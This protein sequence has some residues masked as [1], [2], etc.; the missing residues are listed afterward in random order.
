MAS[1]FL[2]L[3]PGGTPCSTPTRGRRRLSRGRSWALATALAHLL[4]SSPG[5]ANPLDADQSSTTRTEAPP[6]DDAAPLEENDDAPSPEDEPTADDE[7]VPDPTSA[8][9]RPADEDTADD[10]LADE[11]TADD[12]PDDDAPSHE[13]EPTAAPPIPPPT[14]RL[15]ADPAPPEVR[16]VYMGTP[17]YTRTGLHVRATLGA[18][19]LHIF[20]SSA[21]NTGDQPD[22]SVENSSVSAVPTT[23]ELWIGGAL[24]RDLALNLVIRGGRASNGRLHAD[25]RNAD[26]QD[27]GIQDADGQEVSLEGGLTTAFLGV[28]L[29]YHLDPAQGWLI[30]VAA[31]FER[32]QASFNRDTDPQVGGS[33]IAVSLLGGHDWWIG[34]DTAFGV[35][36][37]LDL[38]AATG[39][40]QAEVGQLQLENSDVD[41]Y[42]QAGVAL[43]LSYF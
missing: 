3:H 2:V 29:L 34:E 21:A 20:N 28:G 4:A 39:D 26:G 11:E 42:L 41:F 16:G 12:T 32:W 35:I 43:S 37:K 36:T 10:E 8:D 22:F 13:D 27:S 19:Y 1:Y 30:G 33:G 9:A 38:G 25:V 23:F 7:P 15:Y 18:G 5:W 6:A 40:G 24:R 17:R 31:G 14:A